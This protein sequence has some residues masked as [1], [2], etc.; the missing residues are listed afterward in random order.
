MVQN[1]NFVSWSSTFHHVLVFTVKKRCVLFI[2]FVEYTFKIENFLYKNI[3]SMC[4]RNYK[5]LQ[6]KHTLLRYLY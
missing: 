2:D 6:S 1:S 3:F 5:V 4:A